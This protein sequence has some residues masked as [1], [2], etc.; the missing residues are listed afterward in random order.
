MDDSG[1]RPSTPRDRKEKP[2]G[3]ST[4]PSPSL[5]ERLLS[6]E[7]EEQAFEGLLEGDPL[8]IL[9]RCRAWLEEHA[10][11]LD[12]VKLSHKTMALA[13]LERFQCRAGMPIGEW[14]D[15]RIAIAGYA[16]IEEDAE[17]ERKGKPLGQPVETR[18]LALSQSLGI[19][20]QYA[21]QG[22]IVVNG[23]SEDVRRA[24]HA[25]IIQRRKFAEYV[26]EHGGNSTQTRMLLHHALTAI[27]LMNEDPWGDDEFLKEEKEPTTPS[28]LLAGRKQRSATVSTAET[29][30]SCE[31]EEQAFDGLLQGDPL[32]ILERC[33]AWLEKHAFLLDDV[34]LSQKTMALAVLERSQYQAGMPI[35]EWLDERIAI[36]GCALI[37]E[38]AEEERKGEPLAQP[39]E[40]RLLGLSQILGIELQYSRKGCIVVNGLPEDLRRAFH[41]LIIQRRKFAEYVAEHGGNSTQTRM[42]LHRAL[43]AV[44]LM[45]EDPWGDDEFLREEERDD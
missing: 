23:F 15:E 44:S 5:I 45:N 41:V 30:L 19:K 40:T 34:R 37:D 43:T 26:A 32:G 9:D 38:D 17:E 29:L 28:A 25:L 4:S 42:L 35:G 6:C 24:F 22:C 1:Q 8:G 12:D 21:R 36:A 20:L 33:R 3:R 13:V 18:L 16:L 7:D 31:D 39:V 2:G 27:S 14:L 11:L 10:F